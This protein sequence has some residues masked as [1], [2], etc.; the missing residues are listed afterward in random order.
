MKRFDFHSKLLLRQFFENRSLTLIM[1]HNYHSTYQEIRLSRKV[2][3]L[4][5][6]QALLKIPL[7]IYRSLK[8][9]NILGVGRAVE[10]RFITDGIR[11]TKKPGYDISISLN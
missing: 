10:L 9:V 11:L 3:R 2:E 6:D 5:N 1:G 7:E 8:T 4:T